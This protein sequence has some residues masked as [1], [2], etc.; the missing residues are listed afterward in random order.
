MFSD[1]NFVAQKT[2]TMSTNLSEFQNQLATKYQ[3][4]ESNQQGQTSGYDY[5]KSF[6]EMWQELGHQLMQ[7]GIGKLKAS[8]N[9][10][11][12]ANGTGRNRSA[13]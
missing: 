1:V 10:K 12:T 7:E 9:L 6:V 8:R 2:A 11:K 5:E 3:Q 4:W 13:Q